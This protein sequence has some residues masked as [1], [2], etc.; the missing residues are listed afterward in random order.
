MFW[1]LIFL[2]NC[3]QNKENEILKIIYNQSDS[4]DPIAI[5][6]YPSSNPNQFYYLTRSGIE[7]KFS[8]VS[9]HDSIQL[10]WSKDFYLRN[11]GFYS[12]E[13]GTW[14]GTNSSYS[15]SWSIQK[16]KI[17]PNSN[18]NKEILILEVL[19]EDPILG[20][21]SS[22]ILFREDGSICYDYLLKLDFNGG[23]SIS[24]K[25]TFQLDSDL[26]SLKFYDG[27]GKLTSVQLNQE[28]I[29][30]CSQ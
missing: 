17:I 26:N 25:Y 5:K 21:V 1:S 27:E 18:K 6:S 7:E 16:L 19:V 15:E 9:L 30:N 28:E 29:L 23:R 22:P 3:V 4:K 14:H 13:N 11:P 20:L 12:Y 8:L 24:K 10:I 2:L